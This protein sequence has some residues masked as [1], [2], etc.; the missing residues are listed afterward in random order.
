MTGVVEFLPLISGAFS[1]LSAISSANNQADNFNN[2]ANAA[3]WNAQ[4]SQQAGANAMQVANANEEATRRKAAVELGKQRGAIA[5]SGAGLDGESYAQ[6]VQNAELDALNT[7]YSGILQANGFASDASQQ[8]Y[9]AGVS[10]DNAGK[11]KDAGVLSAG[12]A[13]LGGVG[14]YY[15]GNE[16]TKYRKS[17][18]KGATV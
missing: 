7:R 10:R 15:A 1:A 12:A 3:D 14:N 8:R 18:L 11:A 6:S 5:E 9:S 13:I 2:Q 4:R 17:Q 16:L